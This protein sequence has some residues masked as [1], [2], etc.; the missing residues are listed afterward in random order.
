MQFGRGGTPPVG[1]LFDAAFDTVADLLAVATLRGL[2]QKNETRVVALSINRPDFQAA[3]FCDAVKRMWGVAF[4]LPVGLAGDRG[5][6]QPQDTPAYAKLLAESAADGNPVYKPAL[7]KF[8]DSADP[9]TV[10]RNGLTASMPKNS[11]VFASGAAATAARLLA[12][13]GS[14]PLIEETVRRLVLAGVKDSP[15]TD[16]LYREWPTEIAVCNFGDALRYP[17]GKM[18]SD[19]PGGHVNIVGDAYRAFGESDADAGP[20]AAALFAIRGAGDLF[21]VAEGKPKRVTI[22]PAKRDGV[23]SA[24]MEAAVPG[25][26]GMSSGGGRR[27]G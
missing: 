23:L 13:R 6:D 26:R 27:R 17:A 21:T 7:L 12:L 11:I 2:Q 22:D 20:S 9:A 15:E 14:K 5:E 18:Q 10:L 19:F 24:V 1:V 8:N 16:R 4:S 3:Q 25:S